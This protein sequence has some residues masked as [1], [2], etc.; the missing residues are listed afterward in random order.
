MTTA[1]DLFKIIL[2]LVAS[3]RITARFAIAV[4]TGHA[5]ARCPGSRSLLEVGR[6]CSRLARFADFVRPN[7]RENKL[8]LAQGTSIRI[9]ALQ[10]LG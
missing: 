7:S 3:V 8:I 10:T 9:I 5:G 6:L 2:A 4:S 1:S